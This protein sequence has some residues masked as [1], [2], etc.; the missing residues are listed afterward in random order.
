LEEHVF[1]LLP[2]YALG[3][4]DKEDLVKVSRHLSGCAV[5]QK[6]LATYYAAADQLAQVVPLRTP[7][8]DLK[9]KILQRTAERQEASAPFVPAAPQP[10]RPQ[11]TARTGD[12]SG[13]PRSTRKGFNLFRGLFA[14]P[15]GLA[16]AVV[17]LVLI[18]F[19]GISNLLLWQRVNDLQARAP[20]ENMQL[21]RLDGTTNAPNAQG[22]IMVFKNETYGTL[23]VENAPPLKAG[24]QYQLWLIRD[25]KRTS[26]GVFSVTEDGYGTLEV[27][28]DQPLENFPS[29]GITIEPT[30][31]S[32][33]PTGKK[34]LG[35][36]L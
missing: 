13:S 20:K 30:G 36:N 28:A 29:Y 21:V 12:T 3:C 17:A 18:V 1:D 4:L 35:G 25:G 23:V 24:Y 9:Q 11:E 33:A 16:F 8:P 7:P 32:P 10:S 5:C 22:Y 26:G 15:V 31:G 19:M 27:S 34:V 14:Q 6:E 2:A